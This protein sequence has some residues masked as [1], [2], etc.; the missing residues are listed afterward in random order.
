MAEG[1]GRRSG[2]RSTMKPGLDLKSGQEILVQVIKEPFGGKGP[3]VT[4][5]IA[6]PGR[7]LVLVRLAEECLPE[8]S[9]D[10]WEDLGGLFLR[11]VA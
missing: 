2:G 11:E 10:E 8:G 7:L 4:T 5:D 6:I 1:N 3:R 9:L